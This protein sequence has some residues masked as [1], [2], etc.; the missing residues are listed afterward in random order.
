MVS[1]PVRTCTG[2]RERGDKA[3]LLRL[4]ARD[5]AVEADPHQVLPGRGAYLHPTEACLDKALKR[6]ALGRALR[7]TLDPGR[8]EGAIRP[9][10]GRDA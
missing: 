3:Q 8:V 10:L 9:A 7:T 6:R 5:G 2:C 1:R 4:V